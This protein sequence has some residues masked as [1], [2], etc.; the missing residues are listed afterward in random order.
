MVQ[1]SAHAHAHTLTHDTPSPPAS[2]RSQ[3]LR[4]DI[5]DKKTVG[6]ISEA[7]PHLVFDA[8]SSALGER[9]R[10]I[11][12][13]LFPPPKVCVLCVDVRVCQRVRACACVRVYTC[14][15]VRAVRVL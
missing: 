10:S 2:P 3:V 1:K 5:G 11:L 15:C 6:T 8:F 4:H 14:A 12:S 13:A 7:Y 9:V